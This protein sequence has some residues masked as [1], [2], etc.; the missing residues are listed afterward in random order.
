MRAHVRV[1]EL[2]HSDFRPGLER[3]GAVPLEE[4]ELEVPH[5]DRSIDGPGS[6][7]PERVVVRNRREVRVV[8]VRH[9]A[10]K[11]RL[12]GERGEWRGGGGANKGESARY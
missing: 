4:H 8:R 3:L 5:L 6:D 2:D 11:G 9:G 10:K 1:D 12:R 7:Q